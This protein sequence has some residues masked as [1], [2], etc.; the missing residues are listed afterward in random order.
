MK[1]GRNILL[2]SLLA[3][4]VAV[5]GLATPVPAAENA[6][7][8]SID[9]IVAFGTSLTD[10]GNAFFWLSEPAN[11]NQNCGAPLNVPPYD[12]LDDLLVPDGPYAKGG[13]HFTNGATWIEGMARYLV[14]SGN[15]R[16]AI[17]NPGM[18][19][20]NYAT[21]GAR[22]VHFPCRFNLPDQVGAYL[23]KFPQTSNQTL[24]VIEIGANDVRDAL[25]SGDPTH[26]ANAI[27]S[28]STSIIQLYGSGAKKFLVLNVPDIGKTPAVR[29]LD[30][31]F[32]QLHI[33]AAAQALSQAYNNGL[34]L[35]VQGLRANLGPGIDIRILDIYSTLNDVL[36]R[37]EYYGFLNT[38]DAC[39]TPNQ[40]PFT[41]AQPDTYVFWDGIHPTKAL[42]AIVAKQAL[43]LILSAP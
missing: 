27:G 33:P 18:E 7:Y 37:P 40:A 26:I 38:T 1:F 19:A 28:L 12:A 24:V 31:I 10:T 3:S 16:P 34:A 9:R 11:R 4:L 14:L 42:H 36:T 25:A 13:H 20:S 32:P 8:A 29:K 43:D 30:L 39:V 21:G 41:C 23:G 15:A 17:Q 6:P 5:G 22:A 35:A 2:S